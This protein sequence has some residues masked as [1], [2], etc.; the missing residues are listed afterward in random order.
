[1][2][3]DELEDEAAVGFEGRHFVDYARQNREKDEIIAQTRLQMG[4]RQVRVTKRF[5]E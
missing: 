3:M 2:T 1:M 4:H 5:L